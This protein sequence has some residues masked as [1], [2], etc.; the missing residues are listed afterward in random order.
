[1]PAAHDADRLAPQDR[2]AAVTGLTGGRGCHD[3]LSRD[4]QPPV[5]AIAGMRYGDSGTD[6]QP[7]RYPSQGQGHQD[8][9]LNSPPGS[10]SCHYRGLEQRRCYHQTITRRA[11][12]QG[13]VQPSRSSA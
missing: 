9:S 7:V 3:L 2:L 13:H 6:G 12:A 11:R 4:A 5:T 1:M 10:R 8:C